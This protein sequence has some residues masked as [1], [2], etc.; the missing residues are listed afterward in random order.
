MNNSKLLIKVSL[1]IIITV[2]IIGLII[3]KSNENERE[4]VVN[5]ST[6]FLNKT[7]NE[8][9]S[10]NSDNKSIYPNLL[11]IRSTIQVNVVYDIKGSLSNLQSKQR[12]KMEKGRESIVNK[13]RN[14]VYQNIYING[15]T[16]K[17]NT[18]A[19]T[20]DD[21]PD[22][23]NTKKILKILRDNKIQATF[24]M[25][26][27]NIKNFPNVVKEANQDG[28]LILGHSYSHPQYTD[29]KTSDLVNELT[30]TDNVIE[31]TIGKRPAITR[32]PYGEVNSNVMKTLNENGYTT[33]I[34]SIDTLDWAN[35]NN[36]QN[37]VSNVVKSCNCCSVRR[38]YKKI[39]RKRL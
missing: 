39:K 22:I 7:P 21:G 2:T 8:E 30:L 37:V 15:P 5:H 16:S 36:K 18:V 26:G 38:N 29:L 25:I 14:N 23:K 24:F 6:N 11:A 12:E 10:K 28:N 4:S 20:F 34:W 17:G 1:F 35:P 13:V 3:S 27:N 32:P 31:Q 33:V 19:L 9:V